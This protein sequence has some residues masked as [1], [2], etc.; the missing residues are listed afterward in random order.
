M[1][2][3]TRTAPDPL[4]PVSLRLLSAYSALIFIFAA[5]LQQFL[6]T[7]YTA[8]MLKIT[9]ISYQYGLFSINYITEYSYSEFPLREFL[10]VRTRWAEEQIYFVFMSGPILMTV[11]GFRA[12]AVRRSYLFA[13]WRWRLALTWA[14]FLAVNTLLCSI[15]AGA[16]FYDGF[17]TA[18]QWMAPGALPRTLTG[19][20]ALL[21]LV[22]TGR[23][24]QRL[25]LET[26]RHPAFLADEYTQRTYYRAVFLRGWAIGFPVLVLFSFP[27]ASFYWPVALLA[28]GVVPL[29]SPVIR[30]QTIVV[31]DADVEAP[32]TRAQILLLSCV[33]AM[34]MA[35]GLVRFDF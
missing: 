19:L 8:V 10:Q 33:A 26:C 31:S 24:W 28:L 20:A 9:A 18:F 1:S 32:V 35:A 30:F 29:S 22:G 7:A 12:L 6:L 3:L 15:V 14:A 34:L 2:D 27:F 4:S 21:V 5:L 11:L 23:Y 17:G 25:F 16:F 13:G